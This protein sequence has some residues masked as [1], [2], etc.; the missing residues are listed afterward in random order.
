MLPV[1][2]TKKNVKITNL[3][4]TIKKNMTQQEGKTEALEAFHFLGVSQQ[5]WQAFGRCYIKVLT[6]HYR[7][8]QQA[9]QGSTSN[10]QAL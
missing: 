9:G 6:P 3:T 8:A 10:L 4:K 1:L 2:P 5:S 7:D